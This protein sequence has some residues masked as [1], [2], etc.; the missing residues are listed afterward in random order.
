MVKSPSS[1]V[2]RMATA[3]RLVLSISSDK[4]GAALDVSLGRP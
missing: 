1:L 2:T 3:P 4:D